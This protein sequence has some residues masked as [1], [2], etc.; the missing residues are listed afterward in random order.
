MEFIFKKS[1]LTS[2]LLSQVQKARLEDLK[3]E[4]CVGWCVDKK[5]RYIVFDNKGELSKIP[6]FYLAS[7]TETE[8]EITI[9]FY[10]NYRAYRKFS[11]INYDE[12]VQQLKAVLVTAEEKGQ[13]FI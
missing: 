8:T 7:S 12:V 1:K 9:R 5:I 6:D 2:K 11:H 10:Y 4:N 13:F 3:A